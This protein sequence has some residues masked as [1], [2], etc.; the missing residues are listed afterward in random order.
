MK[1][2]FQKHLDSIFQQDHSNVEII[3]IDDASTDNG[4]QLAKAKLASCDVAYTVLENSHNLGVCKTINRGIRAAQGKYTCLIASDDILAIGRIKR[5]VKI[6]ENCT[7][8]NIIA[9]HG[10]LQVISWMAH[11]LGSKAIAQKIS[12]II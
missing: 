1:N 4:L 8:I 6:L 7:D 2:I 9:C 10:P 5:H 12:T 3:L 11:F